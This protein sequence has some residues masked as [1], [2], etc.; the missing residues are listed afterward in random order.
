MSQSAR[1]TFQRI[2]IRLLVLGTFWL[3]TVST[4]VLTGATPP[5]VTNNFVA[6]DFHVPPA[7]PGL[8]R[9]ER[10]HHPRLDAGRYRVN[11]GEWTTA[12]A[13]TDA[14]LTVSAGSRVL[15]RPF[16]TK[17]GRRSSVALPE[18]GRA[19]LPVRRNSRRA[20][21]DALRG[22]EAT[23]RTFFV[24][25]HPVTARRPSASCCGQAICQIS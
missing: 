22:T 21:R 5:A 25:V 14:A 7:R 9:R 18:F 4:G 12:F 2:A 3:A 13:A 6:V 11:R 16:A 8:A 20:Q 24:Q 23:E 1:A 15:L 10:P 19:D 17:F